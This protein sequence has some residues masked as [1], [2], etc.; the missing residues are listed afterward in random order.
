[1]S[2][3]EKDAK[4][5]ANL[6]LIL[7]SLCSRNLITRLHALFALVSELFLIKFLRIPL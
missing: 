6:R 1:M 4:R 5:S 3:D 2:V 7:V